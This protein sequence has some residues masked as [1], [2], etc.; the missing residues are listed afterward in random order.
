MKGIIQRISWNVSNE[1]QE[2][3]DRER[4]KSEL[5]RSRFV[6]LVLLFIELILIVVSLL[7]FGN[8]SFYPPQSR[9]FTLYVLLS[10]GMLLFFLVFHLIEK[11]QWYNRKII[12]YIAVCYTTYILLWNVAIVLLDQSHQSAITTYIV[13]MISISFLTG[14]ELWVTITAYV[15][16]QSVFLVLL[17]QYQQDPNVVYGHYVNSTILFIMSCCSAFFLYKYRVT[18]FN[19][20]IT[21]REKND[22]LQQLY[23]MLEKQAHRDGLTGLYNKS[24]LNELFDELWQEASRARQTVAVMMVDVDHFKSYNDTYGHLAGDECL[25]QVAR[26][27]SVYNAEDDRAGVASSFAARAGGEEFI[28]VCVKLT[29]QEAYR[30]A[31]GIK[32]QV[33]QL[34]IPH[35]GSAIGHVTV[36]IGLYVGVPAAKVSKEDFI[37]NADQALYSAK[38]KN[39][40]TVEVSDRL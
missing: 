21:I 18:N 37:E 3:F 16:A 29:E 31:S 25:R 17:P 35:T 34:E 27:L 15:V 10:V 20:V 19:N 6:A 11:K 23:N 32:Q 22:E 5:F 13:A 8:Q 14:S 30:K 1:H 39:R 40:N 7:R 9:Y 36:S 2:A 26:V 33:E 4:I 24:K 28:V 38:R 12:S